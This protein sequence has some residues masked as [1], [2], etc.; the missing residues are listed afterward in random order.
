MLNFPKF[1]LHLLLALT[2]GLLML[3]TAR[4][5]IPGSQISEGRIAEITALTEQAMNSLGAEAEP[6]KIL[7][8]VRQAY[9]A[10]HPEFAKANEATL[11][12][13]DDLGPL[14]AADMERQLDKVLHLPNPQE[15]QQLA[16][17]KYP[18]YKRGDHIKIVYKRTPTK[19]ESVEGVIQD[20][21]NGYVKINSRQIRINDMQGIVGNEPEILKLD[22]RTTQQYR[23]AYL[24]EFLSDLNDKRKAWMEE[25]NDDFQAK[26]QRLAGV[27][28]EKNG[29]TAYNGA[30][31]D[32]Q[33]L[34]P[35]VVPVIINDIQRRQ[36][37]EEKARLDA[38]RMTLAHN[39]E[40]K[41]AGEMLD[42]A[43]MRVSPQVELERRAAAK[44]AAEEAELAR[45]AAEEEAK[46]IAEENAREAELA[47]ERLAKKREE[48]KLAAEKEKRRKELEEKFKPLE[49]DKP[50]MTPMRAV[51]I[52]L[53]V[54]ALIAGYVFWRR[55]MED[56]ND[57]SRFFQGKGKLQKEFWAKV[58]ANEAFKYVAYMFPSM[59]DAKNALARLTY[60]TVDQN[61]DLRSKKD[62]DF[63]AYPHMG[64]A[65]AFV[66]GT[67]L[68]YAL[69]REASGIWPELPGAAY[70]KVSDEPK[71]QIEVPNMEEF[72]SESG[73]K[74]VSEGVEDITLETGEISR[75]FKYSA[76]DTTQALAFLEKFE[77][78]EEG[79]M[80]SVSTKDG[81]KYGKDINGI[82]EM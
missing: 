29:F 3:S 46:R 77:I 82:F 27:E 22:Y 71:V 7:T 60:I 78:T 19:L 31:Y 56:K 36:Q 58:D 70:F 4:A 41:A 62:I 25:N 74:I 76:E 8:T 28:N 9:L 38:I 66:G 45:K 40:A 64:Q 15:Q 43:G 23:Q 2:L 26:H 21:V 61:G 47:K 30:W 50:I 57:V 55:S 65:V 10:K 42:P 69:W 72:T 11:L 44:K 37:R 63:G 5:E 48:A 52:V 81:A 12:G 51:I 73:A 1:R 75:C 79:V 17:A 35:S 20:I 80:V 32:H 16:E 68:H 13:D 24:A 6:A 39:L 34:L 18:L 49:E 54:A 59:S 33:S 67:N 14:V 53:I